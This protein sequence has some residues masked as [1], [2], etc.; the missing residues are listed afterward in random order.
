MKKIRIFAALCCAAVLFAACETN[1]P[2]ANQSNNHDPKSGTK[3]A[4]DLGLSVNWATFNVGATKPE[5]YGNYYAWGETDRR[6]NY[7]W[8]YYKYGFS[9]EELVKYCGISDYAENKTTDTL[10]TLQAMDDAATANWGNEWRMP[11]KDEWQELLTNCT[12]TWEQKDGG[13]KGYTLKS[14]INGNT[15]FLPA[16]GYRSADSGYNSG[17]GYYWSSSLCEE[18]PYGAYSV[19]FNA[20]FVNF[21][22]YF[23]VYGYSI[24]PV[25]NKP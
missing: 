20:D 6:D 3:E 15:I 1:E 23:R 22:A 9:R 12:R 11:T 10:T 7:G 2:N 4:V 16:A 18:A 8:D 5:E 24:R 25:Q 14:K 13:I 21:Y 19:Y 17:Y